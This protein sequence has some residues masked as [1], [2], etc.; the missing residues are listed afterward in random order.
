[1]KYLNRKRLLLAMQMIQSMVMKLKSLSLRMTNL[2]SN[3][4]E[5]KTNTNKYQSHAYKWLAGLDVVL[6]KRCKM[7]LVNNFMMKKILKM[8]L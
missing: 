1:M 8:K 6:I 7:N 3:N 2:Q 5:Y 4:V